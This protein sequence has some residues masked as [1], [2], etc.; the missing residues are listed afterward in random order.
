MAHSIR[1]SSL[2]VFDLMLDRIS[3]LQE[4]VTGQL[5]HKQEGTDDNTLP[6]KPPTSQTYFLSVSPTDKSFQ[7]LSKQCHKLKINLLTHEPLE[8][9]YFMSKYEGIV[10][11]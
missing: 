6:R 10:I 3:W 9:V 8:E 5:L 11:T 2:L 4:N 7:N 1:R